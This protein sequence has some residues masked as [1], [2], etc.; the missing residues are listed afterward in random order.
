M[1]NKEGCQIYSA[2][3]ILLLDWYFILMDIAALEVPMKD[4]EL[5]AGAQLELFIR[6]GVLVDLSEYDEEFVERVFRRKR[7]LFESEYKTFS[8]WCDG[9]LGKGVRPPVAMFA[10]PGGRL[11]IDKFR[12]GA[13]VA[14][15]IKRREHEIEERGNAKVEGAVK[16]LRGEVDRLGIRLRADNEAYVRLVKEYRNY[17][18]SRRRISP[19]AVSR[20]IE[21]ANKIFDAYQKT[22]CEC[23]SLKDRLDEVFKGTEFS[24]QLSS[25]W[26]HVEEAYSHNVDAGWLPESDCFDECEVFRS[27][28]KTG[29]VR[30]WVSI[31]VECRGEF[32]RGEDFDRY[33]EALRESARNARGE[34]NYLSSEIGELG[35]DCLRL[36]SF[37][38]WYFPD[39][40]NGA[41]GEKELE[42]LL[43]NIHGLVNVFCGQVKELVSQAIYIGRDDYDVSLIEEILGG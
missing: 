3:G 23:E 19:S 33:S 13:D 43:F 25:V 21:E 38:N 32:G 4:R 29:R 34:L 30:E 14:L 7:A 5:Y 31:P 10:K 41:R 28:I 1:E 22:Y 2:G 39:D 26:E 42:R 8:S 37:E 27:K 18:E 11:G 9:V 36:E 16:K 12:V 20:D 15:T 6:Y 24:F 17:R 35:L 40:F